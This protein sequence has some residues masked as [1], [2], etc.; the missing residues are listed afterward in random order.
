MFKKLT[1]LAIAVGAV[2]ALAA[3]AVASASAITTEE[4]KLVEVGSILEGTST[5]LT[6]ETEL[7][8]VQCAD[9]HVTSEVTLNNGENFETEGTGGSAKECTLGE[10]ESSTSIE[11]TTWRN[12]RSSTT[13]TGEISMTFIMNTPSGKCHYET[14]EA[15]FHYKNGSDV[16]TITATI[17]E[18]TTP[19][20]SEVVLSGDFTI[21]GKNGKPLKFI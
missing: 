20:C 4:E 19:G 21:I 10:E 5:N 14:E 6:L 18:P 13:G 9:S 17:V 1:L 7:G 8:L 11:D 16:I 15:V 12:F 3:P 2:V